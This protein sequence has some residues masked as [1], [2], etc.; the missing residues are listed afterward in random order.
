MNSQQDPF[1]L[2]SSSSSPS[3]SSPPSLFWSLCYMCPCLECSPALAKN[4]HCYTAI[5]Q[6]YM[7]C[8]H[9]LPLLVMSWFQQP[10]GPAGWSSCSL[11]CAPTSSLLVDVLAQSP[12]LREEDG[13]EPQGRL[14]GDQV[15]CPHHGL[16][17]ARA[18]QGPAR[19]AQGSGRAWPSAHPQQPR[20]SSSPKA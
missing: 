12:N 2:V 7:E 18:A 10:T 15:L 9:C 20:G 13:G 11:P 19:L 14:S 6:P 4:T 16:H 1:S 3:A 17:R 5:A 8:P